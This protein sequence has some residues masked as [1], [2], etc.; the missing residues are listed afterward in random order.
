MSEPER[1]I[2]GRWMFAAAVFA[3]V[4]L[5]YFYFIAHRLDWIRYETAQFYWRVQ[6]LAC[7]N[8]KTEPVVVLSEQ[9]DAA[10][11]HV[12]RYEPDLARYLKT[13]PAA[14]PV[15]T[16]IRRK[17]YLWEFNYYGERYVLSIG[18]KGIYQNWRIIPA[19]LEGCSYR[20]A[21]ELDPT[22]LQAI[23]GTSN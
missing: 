22:V 18:D 15:K 9:P 16:E 3:F 23:E 13:L 7:P 5:G 14:Q 2:I 10:P 11:E 21:S 1:D 6:A 12:I 4:S 20:P 19:Q 8:R 17:G